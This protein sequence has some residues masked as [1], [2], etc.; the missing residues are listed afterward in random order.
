M[1]RNIPRSSYKTVLDAF[2]GYH[3]VN[4]DEESSKLT[5]FST[6]CGRYR[7]LRTPWDHCSAGDTYTKRCDDTI[8]GVE[9]MCKCINATPLYDSDAEQAFFHTFDCLH[10]RG[11]N[12]VTLSPS[13]FKFCHRDIEFVGYYFSWDDYRPTNGRLSI[14]CR[15]FHQPQTSGPDLVR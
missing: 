5:P 10:L 6:K 11:R 8:A 2:S 12:G 4:L 3:Q 7:Y 15:S 13:K 14:I 1:T 9:R